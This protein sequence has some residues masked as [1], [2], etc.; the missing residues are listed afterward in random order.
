MLWPGQENTTL[1]L[2]FFFFLP[3]GQRSR[4]NEDHYGM[5]HTPPYGHA[6]TYQ[7]LTYLK[8]NN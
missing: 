7:L 5:R 1:Y 6:P 8:S 3:S 2:I 4:S